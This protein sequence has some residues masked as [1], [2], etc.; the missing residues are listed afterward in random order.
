MASEISYDLIMDEDMP[1]VEG[2]YRING[3]DWQVFIFIKE[4]EVT[5][6]VAKNSNWSSGVSGIVIRVPPSYCLNKQSVETLLS[7]FLDVSAWIEVKGP[8]SMQL[9]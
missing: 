8:D 4:S 1:F 9:R 6:V 5:G 3:G 7:E 2:T